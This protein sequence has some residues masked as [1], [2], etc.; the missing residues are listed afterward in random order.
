[1]QFDGKVVVVTGASSGIGRATAVAF[2]REGAAVAH[3]GS[4]TRPQAKQGRRG[5]HDARSGDA[6]VYADGCL[7]GTVTSRPS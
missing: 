7:P 5:D 3:R 6:E 2:A 4:R 1:M